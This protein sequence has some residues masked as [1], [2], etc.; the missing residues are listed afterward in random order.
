M[1]GSVLPPPYTTNQAP[2]LPTR[3]RKSVLLDIF[4]DSLLSTDNDGD[5]E[6]LNDGFVTNRRSVVDDVGR[7]GVAC[8][9]DP[10]A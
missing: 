8:L 2:G 6:R 10:G 7:E 1:P 4:R 3:G 5:G 9:A